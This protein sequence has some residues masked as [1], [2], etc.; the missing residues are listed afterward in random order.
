MWR[1]RIAKGIRHALLLRHVG[2]NRLPEFA[3]VEADTEFRQIDRKSLHVMVVIAC[4][5]PQIFARKFARTPGLIER[6]TKQ[7][8][9]RDPRVQLFEEL[10]SR[11]MIA[12][13]TLQYT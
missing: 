9:L 3:F 2:Q 13:R 8:I 7:I 12:S 10:L 6:M 5:L 4:V 11:H 1:R